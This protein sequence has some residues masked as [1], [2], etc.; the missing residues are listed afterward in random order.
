M[1]RHELFNKLLAKSKSKNT[2][3]LEIGVDNPNSTYLN[4]VADKKIAVDPYSD[5]SNKCHLWDGENRDG[6]IV[7]LENGENST[8]KRETSDEYFDKLSKRTKFDLIFIDGLH[9]YEQVK[10]DVENAL[11][12]L[13]TGGLIILDDALPNNALEAVEEPKA[14]A[15]WRGTVYKYVAEERIKED[16][17]LTIF[18]SDHMNLAVIQKG[19]PEIPAFKRAEFPNPIISY[20]FY[21]TFKNE[22]MN[23]LPFKDFLNKLGV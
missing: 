22:L 12:H 4:V 17:E 11:K 16:S 10:K 20:E 19:N 7:M 3:Y 1:H 15:P 5:N 8:F 18:C 9:T 14:G 23:V 13:K 21:Y 6:F 2:S